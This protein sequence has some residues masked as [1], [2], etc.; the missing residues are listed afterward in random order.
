LS[1]NLV[2]KLVLFYAPKVAATA[3]V[4][5]VNPGALAMPHMRISTIR[6]SGSDIS[7]VAYPRKSSL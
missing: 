5:F 4:P 7:I 6:Q 3:G 1:A 2:N